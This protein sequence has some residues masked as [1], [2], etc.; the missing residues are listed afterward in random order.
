MSVEPEDPVPLFG[1]WK[2]IYAA[3]I[4]SAIV[5]MALVWVFTAVPY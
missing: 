4:V 1:S 3:V 5:V 2:V